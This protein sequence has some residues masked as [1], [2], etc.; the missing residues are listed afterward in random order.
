MDKYNE[1]HN[2]LGD[3]AYK[4]KD[5]LHCQFIS[6]SHSTIT[7]KNKYYHLNFTMKIKGADDFDCGTDDLYFVEIKNVHG[8]HEELVVSRFC[9]VKPN[10]NGHCYGCTNNGSAGMKHP[11]NSDAYTGGHVNAYL[12]FEWSDSE[13]MMIYSLVNTLICFAS[14]LITCAL[15]LLQV[16]EEARIRHIYKGFGCL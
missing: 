12:P 15:C 7:K 11:N 6:E 16:E 3:L 4:L 9:I 13:D 5:V 1:D 2:L 14:L 10:D 8:E